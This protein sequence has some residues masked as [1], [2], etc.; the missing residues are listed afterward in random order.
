MLCYGKRKQKA[1]G[2]WHEVGPIME[3]GQPTGRWHSAGGRQGAAVTRVRA[4]AAPRSSVVT[5]LCSPGWPWQRLLRNGA[6]WERG[7]WE[8]IINTTEAT[9]QHFVVRNK[10]S[11]IIVLSSETETAA[12]VPDTQGARE[13]GIPTGERDGQPTRYFSIWRVKGNQGW[14]IRRQRTYTQ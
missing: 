1:Q 12:R 7:G 14:I 5:V 11:V 3:T 10:V 2:G 9:W 4:V 13:H 6:P 8:K